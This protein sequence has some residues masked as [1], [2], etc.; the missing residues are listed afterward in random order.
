V[1]DR[2]ADLYRFFTVSLPL[3]DLRFG[4]VR[5]DAGLGNR[6]PV[7]PVSPKEPLCG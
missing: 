5:K 6:R 3:F 1:F 2:A 7:I 4:K